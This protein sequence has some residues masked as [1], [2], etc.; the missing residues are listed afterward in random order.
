MFARLRGAPLLDGTRGR[1]P[2]DVAGLAEVVTR[3]ARL[4]ESL[5]DSLESFEV[6]PLRVAGDEIEAL[7][8]LVVWRSDQ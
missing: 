3:I 4:A 1:P 7:D 5:G 8:A 2:A 6:N